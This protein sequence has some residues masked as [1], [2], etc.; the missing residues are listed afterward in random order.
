[1]W[2][3]F[4]KHFEIVFLISETFD[5]SNHQGAEVDGV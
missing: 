5:I 4:V 2:K 3:V 1:M